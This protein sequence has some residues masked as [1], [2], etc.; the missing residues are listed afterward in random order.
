MCMVVDLRNFSVGVRGGSG[1]ASRPR[2]SKL[3]TRLPAGPR[4]NGEDG[5]DFLFPHARIKEARGGLPKVGCDVTGADA[6]HTNKTYR[7]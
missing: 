6:T 4:R 5:K 7:I 1:T 3:E 2:P